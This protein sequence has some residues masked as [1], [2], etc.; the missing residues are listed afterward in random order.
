MNMKRLSAIFLLMVTLGG[1]AAAQQ[2]TIRMSLILPFKAAAAPSNNSFDFYSG[3][4]LSLQ[5]FGQDSLAVALEVYDSADS[6]GVPLGALMQN[7][8][9]LGP[10]SAA[11]ITPLAQSL[12]WNKFIISPLDPACAPLV[13]SLKIIQAP[14]PSSI[15]LENLVFWACEDRESADSVL[16]ICEENHYDPI[17][18]DITGILDNLGESYG[19]VTCETFEDIASII[20]NRMSVE[21]NNR[22]ILASER[23]EFAKRVTEATASVRN[24]RDVAL[25]CPV[26]T[27]SFSSISNEERNAAGVRTIA[28]YSIDENDP[29]TAAF[30]ARYKELYGVVPNSFAYQGYDLTRFFITQRKENGYRWYRHLDEQTMRGLQSDFSFERRNVGFINTAVRRIEY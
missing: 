1:N 9:L 21:G 24:I 22:I 11:D 14:A 19:I 26:K 18:A 12:F 20:G 30:I 8:I 10:I 25:F 17:Q 16:V 4:L 28:S 2:D 23:E 7:D 5:E 3:V 29:Q 6:L 13:D 15:Q 27:R